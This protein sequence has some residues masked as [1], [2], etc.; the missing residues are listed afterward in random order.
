MP[1]LLLATLPAQA[2]P[3]NKAQIFEMVPIFGHTQMVENALAEHVAWRIEQGDPW[4]WDVFQVVVGDN[5][6]TF[7]ARSGNHAW[8]DFDAYM[9]E[10]APEHFEQT[11]MPHLQSFSSMITAVDTTNV[12]WDPER[13]L[14]LYSIAFYDLIPEK[15]RTFNEALGKVS[16]VIRESGFDGIHAFEWILAGGDGVT[17]VMGVFPQENW[18]DFEEPDPNMM[19]IMIAEH[20]EETTMQ[21]FSD[22]LSA[23]RSVKNRVLLH[24][25]DLSVPGG[26]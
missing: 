14:T 10:G 19:Q 7:Y 3:M 6:N 8:V 13:T 15:Q 11:V 9:I 22:F 23:V 2:Q 18:A 16:T 24:R 4:A 25:T 21:I 17:D 12:Y 20:G 5:M 26:M 1:V